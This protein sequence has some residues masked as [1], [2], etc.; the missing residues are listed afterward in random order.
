MDITRRRLFTGLAGVASAAT[1]DKLGAQPTGPS[2]LSRAT[3]RHQ[4]SEATFPRMEDFDIAEGYTYMNGA[5]PHPMP[6]AAANAFRAAVDRRSKLGRSPARR[7][8]DT[9]R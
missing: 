9:S 1:I 7:A 4:G 5:F 2:T 6:I 3:V 8:A